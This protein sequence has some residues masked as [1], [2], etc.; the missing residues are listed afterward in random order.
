MLNTKHTAKE[1]SSAQLILRAYTDTVLQLFFNQAGGWLWVH[2]WLLK[3]FP[4]KCV[5]VLLLISVTFEYSINPV[6]YSAVV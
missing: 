2:A 4:E 3:L 5:S 6:S 1:F